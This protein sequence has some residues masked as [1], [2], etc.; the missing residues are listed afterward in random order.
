MK[1]QILL[2]TLLAS[3]ISFQVTVSANSR[4]D[5]DRMKM[6]EKHVAT[7]RKELKL[8]DEQTKEVRELFKDQS[9][10]M[11][12]VH[13]DCQDKLKDILTTQQVGI[14]EKKGLGNDK[15]D[16]CK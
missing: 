13:E 10:K 15:K 14:Y 8:T 4:H 1:K 12:K 9:E 5:M 2:C 3:V 7:L 11:M 6:Q 16:C